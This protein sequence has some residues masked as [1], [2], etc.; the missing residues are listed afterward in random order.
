[1]A[2]PISY[3]V[4]NLFVRWK[5]TLL[6]IFGIGLVILVFVVLLS[7]SSGFRLMLR[8]TGSP[9]N[10]IVTQQGSTSELTSGFTKANADMISDDDRVARGKDGRPMASPEIMVLVS[11]IKR[12]NEQPTNL[13]VRAV[14]REAFE[15]RNN[16]KIV[17]GRNFT[18]GLYEVIIGKRLQG[19]YVGLDIGSKFSAMKRDFVVVGV[20][21]A[22]A[23]SFE[24]EI[25][26]DYDAMGTAFNRAGTASSLTVRLANPN[27]LDRFD[28]DIKA[29]PQFQLQMQQERQYYENQAGL[30]AGALLGLAF[31]VSIVMGVG[32]VF[33]AMNTMYAIVASR[34]REIGTLRAL[35]FSR[36]AILFGFL[37]ESAFLALVG[38]VIACLLA[39]V[40][41]GFGAATGF[42]APNFS[43]IAFAFRILP[44]H[45]TVGLI[46]A[47]TMGIFG[48]MLPAF[49]A[50]KLPI[51][52][53][54]REA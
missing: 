42:G 40:V 52:T 6:A 26:G 12:S 19:R 39:S 11:L 30:T 53:A 47:V 15:V 29:N 17:Q 7:M 49:R 10:A 46:F 50:A 44:A 34:T 14:T 45:L 48:G 54:L 4:R 27:S 35:G 28:A 8:S 3:N 24:S 22:D 25:W 1:M 16:V 41:N 20:F 5:V 38:G 32:A 36:G 18:P 13:T 33:G 23:S 51:T 2:L 9:Q 31:F 43:E 37:L 21:T